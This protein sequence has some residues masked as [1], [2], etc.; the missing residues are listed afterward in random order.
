MGAVL[1]GTDGPARGR[2]VPLEGG[3]V[4]LGRHESNSVAIDDVAAS[5]HHCVI[6][7]C[8]DQF[9]LID[10][11][12]RNGTFVNGLM[13]NERVLEDNDEIR[14]GGSLFLFRRE[15]HTKGSRLTAIHSSETIFLNPER[16]EETLPPMDRTAHG[17]HILLRISQALQ[18]AQTVEAL[19]RHLIQL[20]FEAVP[21]ECGC[22]VLSTNAESE[23]AFTMHRGPGAKGNVGE[24]PAIDPEVSQRAREERK[25]V[26]KHEEGLG[27]I[28]A[29]LVCFEQMEG[30]LYLRGSAELAQFDNGDLEL[31]SA[32]GAIAGMA[33]RNLRSFEDLRREKERLEEEIRIEHDMVGNSRKMRDL[34]KFISLVAAGDSTVLIGGESGTGKELVARAIHQNSSRKDKPFVAINCAA[35]TETLLESELFGHEKGSFTGAIGMKKGM[36][37]VAHGGTLFLDEIGELAPALQAKLLR[38]LETQEFMRVGGTRPIQVDVRIVAATNRNLEAAVG[39]KTF[40]QDLYFRLNVISRTLPPLRERR[41]DIPA[42]ANHFLKKIGESTKRNV[43]GISEKALAALMKYH[44]EGGNVRELRNAIEHAVVLGASD[45]ILPEDLPEAVLETVAAAPSGSTE[46]YQDA[47]VGFKRVKVTEALQRANG[48]ITEAA[49]LLD[50]HPNYLHRLMKNLQLR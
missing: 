29:P 15:N 35:L 20:L 40:R 50:V 41:E 49:K 47:V 37:E 36:F 32:V 48:V 17:V 21:A 7:P 22:I 44:W 33:I 2:L 25:A 27:L 28:A 1:L 13:V 42:L 9:K 8:G 16:L 18:E 6:S 5:K 14:V 43:K 46:T 31:V 12:S 30:L 26:L 45:K 4:S 23:T 3:E 39:N 24:I 38:A 34:H 10:R 11:N 19:E